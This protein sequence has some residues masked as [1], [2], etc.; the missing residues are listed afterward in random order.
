MKVLIA[1]AGKLGFR[2]ASALI[3]EKCDVTMLDSNE[4]VIENINNSLDVLTVNANALDFEIL[5]ELDMQS[6]DLLLATTTSDEANVLIST[7]SKKLGIKK[8]IARVRNP[9]Y[10]NQIKFIMTEL[11]IDEIINPDYA[12]AVSIEK[13]LLKKYLLMSDDF[14]DGR[15]K[16]VDFHIGA[17][18]NFVGRRLMDLKGFDGLLITAITRNGNTIIPNGA[19]VLKEGDVILIAGA[20]QDI[21]DFDRKHSGIN[22]H[23]SVKRVM[24]LGG[25]KLGLYLGILLNDAGIETTIIEI[26]KNRCIKLKEMLP[27]AI[28]INGDGTDYNLLEEEVVE[29]YDAFVATTGFDE[30]NLLMALTV[31]QV[32]VYKSVA[33][34]SRPNYN[35]IIGKLG[36]D[37]AFN[38]SFITASEILKI[39]R[40]EGSLS[41][42]LMLDGETEFTEIRLGEDLDILNV[43]IKDLKL[44][45]GVLITTI[46]RKNDV[47]IPNGNSILL[48]EDRIIVFFMH[49]QIDKV[50]G[51]FY[52]KHRRGGLISELRNYI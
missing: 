33:K 2:L 20:S 12:T 15:V 1:G 24:I 52:P 3:S 38:T 40:G 48:P 9:E 51:F 37:A 28:I 42:S 18:E 32:G 22:K 19:T 16:L 41:V 5:E 4:K 23:K 27:N 21:E 30:T 31:K 8:V 39:I 13:Y 29:S 7:I 46:V 45:N 25:G 43:P 36:V 26:D 10:H 50:K 17:D 44:P 14:A 47:I 11:G 34:I 6:Y 49:D 35:K